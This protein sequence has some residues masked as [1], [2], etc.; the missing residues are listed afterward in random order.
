M[1]SNMKITLL[2]F[3]IFV[4]P[5][6]NITI[7][8]LKKRQFFEFEKNKIINSYIC[9]FCIRKQTKTT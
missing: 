9:N 8:L 1:V 3:S 7:S 4:F 5:N 6:E 2:I